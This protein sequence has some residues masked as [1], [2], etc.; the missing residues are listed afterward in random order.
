MSS[1]ATV[2][3]RAVGRGALAGTALIL[4]ISSAGALIERAMD[5]FDDSSWPVTIFLAILLAFAFAGWWAA[6]AAGSRS[7]LTTGAL[8]GLGAFVV[9]IPI[10]VLIWVARDDSKGLFTGDDPVFTLGGLFGNIVFAAALGMLGALLAT[11][12]ATRSSAED[13]NA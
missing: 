7:P 13:S 1:A 6:R 5:D 9:W 2:D 8:A 3:T 10:R 11:R 4:V 12:R